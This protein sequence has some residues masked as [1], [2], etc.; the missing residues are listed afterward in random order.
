MLNRLPILCLLLFSYF[1]ETAYATTIPSGVTYELENGSR[2]GDHLMAYSKA[3]WISYKYNIPFYYKPFEFSQQLTMHIKEKWLTRDI[4][5]KFTKVIRFRKCATEAIKPNNATLYIIYRS[6]K[7]PTSWTYSYGDMAETFRNHQAFLNE[8]KGMILPLGN[9]KTLEFPPNK[10]SIAIHARRGGGVDLPLYQKVD[11]SALQPDQIKKKFADKKWPKKFPPH[12]FYIGQIKLIAQEYK[13][14]PL[15]IHIFTDD[16]NPN[17]IIDVYKKA[18]AGLPI[19]F[20]C[21]EKGNAHNCNVLDDLFAMKNFDILIRPESGLSLF[22]QILGNHK[23]VIYP[24]HATWQEDTT[25][26]MDKLGFAGP[27]SENFAKQQHP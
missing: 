24:L 21:R 19:T 7:D 25:L 1:S 10:L 14:V 26:T 3:K 12:N 4:E 17:D 15:Y 6:F 9:I 2:L 5:K 27:L 23:L 18:L 16:P 20:G 11:A 22:S 13:G 8:L